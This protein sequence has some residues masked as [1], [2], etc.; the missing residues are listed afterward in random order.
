MG[1]ESSERPCKPGGP[2][3]GL[4]TWQGGYSFPATSTSQFQA[5][6]SGYLLNPILHATQDAWCRRPSG[7]RLKSLVSE[8]CEATERLLQCEPGCF[9]LNLSWHCL[10]YWVLWLQL[11][12]A[13]AWKS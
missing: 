13:T 1:W 8:S 7:I 5:T 3:L 6:V 4:E 10:L 12:L 11:R 9:Q 2:E